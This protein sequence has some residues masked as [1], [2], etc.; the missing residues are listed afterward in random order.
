MTAEAW[1]AWVQAGGS[2]LA[3][4][5]GFGTVIYQNRHADKVQEAERERRAEVV[6]LAC[7]RFRGQAVKLI[8]PFVRTQPG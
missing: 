2:I 8:R 6:A 7:C 5:A 1:A 4:A 3:I